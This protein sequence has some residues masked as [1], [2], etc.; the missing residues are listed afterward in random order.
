MMSCGYSR[1]TLYLSD[2]LT[3]AFTWNE[4][5]RSLFWFMFMKVKLRCYIV[6]SAQRLQKVSN[7]QHG[8][9]GWYEEH[10]PSYSVVT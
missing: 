8:L 6:A 9:Q 7:T 10:A 4:V 3:D 5:G 1:T 2:W